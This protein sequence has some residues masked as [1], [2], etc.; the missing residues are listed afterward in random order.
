MLSVIRLNLICMGV[1]RF[2]DV[3]LS[4]IRFSIK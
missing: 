1:A 2:S 4:V 3:R